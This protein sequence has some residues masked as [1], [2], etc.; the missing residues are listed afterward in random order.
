M[1][2]NHPHWESQ[3]R[4]GIARLDPIHKKIINKNYLHGIEVV[5]MSTFS[6]EALQIAWIII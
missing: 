3:R 1:F 2:W 6:E 4:D 5:N